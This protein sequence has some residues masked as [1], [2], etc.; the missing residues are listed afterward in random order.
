[1]LSHTLYYI[2]AITAL[3]NLQQENPVDIPMDLANQFLLLKRDMGEFESKIDDF[4]R[5]KGLKASEVAVKLM[6]EI[7]ILQSEIDR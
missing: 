1:M 3:R 2:L 7:S 5:R 4:V 6:E